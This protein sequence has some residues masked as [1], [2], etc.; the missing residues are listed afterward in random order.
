MAMKLFAQVWDSSIL[1]SVLGEY[2]CTAGMK[3]VLNLSWFFSD[4][5]SEETE[6]TEKGEKIQKEK[7]EKQ[8]RFGE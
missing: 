1:Q 7:E 3:P 5:E 6:E 8:I 2:F 4:R